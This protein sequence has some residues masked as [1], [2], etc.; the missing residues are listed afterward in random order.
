MAEKLNTTTFIKKAIEIHNNKYDYSKINYINY[1]SKICIICFIHGE[2][3]QTPKSHICKKA[4]G[5]PK[6]VGKNITTQEFI[7]KAKKLNNNLYDYSL[8]EYR[9]NSTKISIICPIHGIFKQT[10][11][12]HLR[13]CGCPKCIGKQ[14]ELSDFITKSKKV[15]EDLYNYDL[16]NYKNSSEKVEIICKEHGSFWQTPTMHFN[17]NG[18]PKCS[19]N[20]KLTQEEYVSKAIKIHNGFYHY[21]NTVYI[22]SNKHIKIECP[23]HGEFEQLAN[24]HLAGHGCPICR[25]INASKS[26]AMSLE[27]FTEKANKIHNFKYDYQLVN[28]KNCQIKVDIICPKHGKF[29]QIPSNHL[30]GHGCA[31]CSFEEN[32]GTYKFTEWFKQA[33]KS[34]NYKGFKVYFIKCYNENEEFY[35]IGKSFLTV[36]NRFKSKK[37]MP[38]SYDIIQ[39]TNE[40]TI[41]TKENALLIHNL[42]KEIKMILKNKKYTP[43]LNFGGIQECYT[44][45]IPEVKN[46]TEL[47]KNRVV[48]V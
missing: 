11:A 28:Y 1:N 14:L 17:G 29:L 7:D 30:R 42:E 37:S 15:H 25:Y 39:T 2:F 40:N 46:I 35:K 21:S 38:Y 41:L 44:L 24:K 18:C 6:C 43:I 16:V 34:K 23:K 33:E 31:K 47:L 22:N 9:N 19:K 4:C 10:P 8:V 26:N 5:C 48:T 20:K 36:E 13:P 12:S 32:S 3:W 27:E 45:S